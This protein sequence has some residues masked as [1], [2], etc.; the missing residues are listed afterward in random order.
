MQRPR[1]VERE[2]VP[3]I[4]DRARRRSALVQ[5]RGGAECSEQGGTR[6]IILGCTLCTRAVG[7]PRVASPRPLGAR[8]GGAHAPGVRR[9]EGRRPFQSMANKLGYKSNIGCV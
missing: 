5:G 1:L 8:G 4:V 6:A 9:R 7:R 3:S 2:T